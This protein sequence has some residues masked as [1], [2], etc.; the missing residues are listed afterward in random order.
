MKIVISGSPGSGKTSVIDALRDQGYHCLEEV[1]RTVIQWGTDQGYTNYFLEDPLSFSEKIWDAR[2]EQFYQAKKEEQKHRY[3]FLD[4]GLHDSVAYLHYLETQQ[5][6]WEE[7]LAHY[8]YDVVFLMPPWEAIYK[9]DKQRFEDFNTAQQLYP[10]LS[11]VYHK[12]HAHVWEVPFDTVEKRVDFILNT[13]R[14]AH[15]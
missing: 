11:K 13:L 9:Q 8:T 1:S 4:R 7:Q 3:S 12:H 15:S 5:E 14:N 2:R 10:F 6:E